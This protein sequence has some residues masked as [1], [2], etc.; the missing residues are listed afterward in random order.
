MV[1]PAQIRPTLP[2]VL[3]DVFVDFGAF[4]EEWLATPHPPVFF[5]A[6]W[7]VGMD[8]VAGTIEFEYVTGGSY[9]VA[10]WFH[11]WVRIIAGGILAGA[12]RYWFAGSLFHLLAR[13]AGARMLPRT[14]RYVLLYASLPVAVIDLALKVV[15]MF[16]YRNAYF[17]GQ[18][19]PFVDGVIGMVMFGAF[20]FTARLCFM[21][22]RRM[23]NAPVVRATA[24][25]LSAGALLF[26][27]AA[28]AARV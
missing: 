21:G 12:I 8:V 23:G 2:D 25:M 6:A 20:V 16:G 22:M 11:A 1:P 13:A 7:I 5:F 27:L 4:A 14:S 28:V 19:E 3:R 10:D 26:F 24:V 17:T 18:T 9:L 15:Q